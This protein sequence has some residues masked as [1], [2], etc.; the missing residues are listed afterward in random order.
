MR[1]AASDPHRMVICNGFAQGLVLTLRVLR[2]S[3]IRRVAIEDP[4]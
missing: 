4:G 3:G 1:A 2:R